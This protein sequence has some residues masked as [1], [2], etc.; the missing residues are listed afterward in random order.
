MAL[1]NDVARRL[2]WLARRSRF[3]RELDDEIQFHIEMR[4]DELERDGLPRAEALH[5]ARRQFGS[6]LRVSEDSRSAWH[7]RWLA[8]LCADLRYAA[9]GFRRNP[10]FTLTAI[11][12][13]A[14]GVGAN[15]TVFSIAMEAL[16]SEPSCRDS[17]SLVQ[18]R[19]AG[20]S[21]WPAREYRFLRDSGAFDGLAGM[22][23]GEVV[24]WRDADSSRRIAGTRV[25]SNFFDV[26]GVPVAM[27]RP[28][29]TG[30]SQVAVLTHG[31]WTRRLGADPA[32]VGRKLVLDGQPYTVVG[33]LPREHRNLAGFG[34]MPDLY[35]TMDSSEYLLFARLPRDTTLQA[36]S[37]R[38][39]T[40]S[41]ELDRVYPDR[42]R[43]RPRQAFLSGVGGI[44][45]LRAEAGEG[46]T[47][48][49]IVQAVAFFAML[50]VVTGLVLLIACANV[51][52]L[53]LARGMSRSHEFAIRASLGGGRGRILR[54]LMAE[55]LLLAACGTAAGLLVNLA[56]TRLLGSV[57]LSIWLPIEFLIQ[58]DRRLLAYSVAI[59]AIVSVAAGLMPALRAARAG[60][61]GALKQVPPPAAARRWTLRNALVVSQIAVSIVLLSG[62]WLF[63]RNL[64][65]AASSDPG[66][67]TAHTV[68]AT[69]RAL[70]AACTPERFHLLTNTAIDR[71]R[72]LPGVDSASLARAV[73]LQ[74]PFRISGRLRPDARGHAVPVQYNFNAVGP[75]Y[76][77]TMG[78]HLVEGRSF[79][80]SDAAKTPPVVILNENLA[81]TLFGRSTAAGRTLALPDGR[82]VRVVG[83][84]RNSKYFMLGEANPA[85]LYVPWSQHADGVRFAHF[86]IRTKYASESTVRDVDRTLAALDPTIAV[87]VRTMRD[88]LQFTLLPSRV[89]AGVIGAMALLGLA[90]AS[91]GLYGVLLY[92]TSRRVREIGIRVA[93]GASPH[94]IVRM[95][96]G[97]SARLVAA[98]LAIGI[99]LSAM[100]VRPLAVFLVPEVRPADPM[101]FVAVSAGLLLVAAVA[102]VSPALHALRIDPVAALRH[103]E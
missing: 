85:A 78:I 12:C 7:L 53:L 1:W 83:I 20:A 38:L 89:G 70:P 74:S 88:A 5:Q 25:T 48:G 90:L 42:G 63:V 47:G 95:I 32:V 14:L 50:V 43:D 37:G 98:G 84:A 102:T 11:S 87:E 13:L 18:L 99:C 41:R 3:E 46:W 35:L 80:A 60:I 86:L 82:V 30:E 91:I 61:S 16:F 39:E 76:F 21:F 26:T 55:S 10:A 2:A 23:I 44:D 8:D 19:A 59:A 57:R 54:Q 67:D 96:A 33:V 52:S 9:R 45:R 64:F 73:P 77:R 103:D 31:F 34:F 92:T 6:R 100:A 93:L 17:R 66:F 28:I 49:G 79:L 65:R 27:G 56:L 72:A 94:S 97:E 29:R 4:A 68:W 36:A 71:L 24:N 62:G 15:T 22:N 81:R 75:D 69:F 58:P 101:N 40:I 51:S